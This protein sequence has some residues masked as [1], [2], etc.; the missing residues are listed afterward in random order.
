MR[1]CMSVCVK[2]YVSFSFS[3]PF[4]ISLHCF[5]VPFLSFSILSVKDNIT[6]WIFSKL[7]Y[8]F[9]EAFISVVTL[10]HQSY[11]GLVKSSEQ[12]LASI[13]FR[14]TSSIEK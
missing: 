13:Q 11:L 3:Y 14:R 4:L 12:N 5:S 1:V 6:M 8:F 2:R 10:A 7:R 9:T